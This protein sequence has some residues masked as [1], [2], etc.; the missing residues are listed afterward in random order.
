MRFSIR[1]LLWLTAVVALAATVCTDRVRMARQARQWAEEKAT[2]QRETAAAMAEMRAKVAQMR[3]E[4]LLQ[5]HRFNL[6]LTAERQR[7][8]REIDHARAAA[9]EAALRLQHSA[10]TAAAIEL[11]AEARE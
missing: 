6:Q 8:E 7:Y 11:A 1:D 3:T 10:A 4:N 9:T 5:E 2:V